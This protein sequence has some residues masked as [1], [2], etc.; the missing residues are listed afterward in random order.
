MKTSAFIVADNDTTETETEPTPSP[1]EVVRQASLPTVASYIVTF[2]KPEMLHIYRQVSRLK[3]WRTVVFCQ[4]HENSRRF[5]MRDVFV[6]PKPLTHQIRR[7]WQKT[8]KDE[9][10]TIADIERPTESLAWKLWDE[11][12]QQFG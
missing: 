5:P 2:L 7:F 1:E 9:P 8:V 12:V 6:V 11:Q 10:I 3:R 4:K